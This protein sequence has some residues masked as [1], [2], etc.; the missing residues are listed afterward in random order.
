MHARIDEGVS[1]GLL[2]TSFTLGLRHGFD[3]DHIAAIADLSGTA[4]SRRRGFALS[5]LYALGHGAVVFTLGAIAIAAGSSASRSL[6]SADGFCL[7][8]SARVAIS[9]YAAAGC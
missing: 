5:M 4:E 7:S 1:L 9:D 6:R 3:W 8:S 2:L